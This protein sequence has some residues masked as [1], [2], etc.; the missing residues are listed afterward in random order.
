MNNPQIESHNEYTQ[1]SAKDDALDLL[2]LHLH[3]Y[4]QMKEA[5][6]LE[7]FEVACRCVDKSQATLAKFMEQE[8]TQY[9][10]P[11]Y[12]KNKI[13]NILFSVALKIV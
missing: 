1:K 4:T 11:A 2:N 13:K 3:Y 6:N 7:E 12:L 8:T 9:Y 10:L 5:T